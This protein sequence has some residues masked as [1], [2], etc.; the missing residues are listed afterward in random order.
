MY[1]ITSPLNSRLLSGRKR[2]TDE[3]LSKLEN[4]PLLTLIGPGGTGKTRLSIQLGAQLLSNFKAGVWLV[5]LAPIS[6]P[7]L[8]MQTI[9]SVFDIGEAPGVPLKMLVH[10]FVREKHLLLIL[11]NCEHLIEASARI[12]DE[13]LHVAPKVKIIV[14]S[15]EA[16]GINGE[17]VYRVPSLSLPNQHQVT[18]E[19]ALGFEFVMLFVERGSAANPNFHLT[20]EN[21]SFVAQI[22]SRLDGIPLAIELAASRITVFSPEQIAKRLDDRFK[23]L[24]GGSR[25]ALPR[26]QT[27]LRLI[28]WSY[29]LLSDGETSLVAQALGFRRRLDVRSRRG[30]LQQCGCICA[31]A[32]AYQQI[33]GDCER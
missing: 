6:H 15:R 22:C 2:E 33:I 1:R 17:T 32:P 21:A 3:A 11:D 5:E 30:D 16:L 13:I 9:A 31:F 28:D 20:D 8:I 10:D 26:Q 23:L 29:E 19:A 4:A 12:A 7:S 27:L 24:T 25:T 14:S 18:K